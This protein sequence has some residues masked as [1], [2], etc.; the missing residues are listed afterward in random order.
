MSLSFFFFFGCLAF[1]GIVV[2]FNIYNHVT[3]QGLRTTFCVKQVSFLVE[4]FIYLLFVIVIIFFFFVFVPL[5]H[6]P[7]L[8]IFL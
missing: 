6:N 5:K 8:V 7:A 1:Y 2:T 3:S 4:L